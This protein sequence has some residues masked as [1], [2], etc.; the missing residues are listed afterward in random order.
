MTVH[1]P[2]LAI[3]PAL[4]L[5]SAAGAPHAKPQKLGPSFDCARAA[6]AIETMICS[7]EE[8]SAY[9]RALGIAFAHAEDRAETAR[10]QRAWLNEDRA[11]CG[12]ADCLAGAYADRLDDLAQFPASDWGTEY[13]SRSAQGTLQIAPIGGGWYMFAASATWEYAH[14]TT[15]NFGDAAG[16]IRPVA[17]RAEFH[18]DCDLTF[19]RLSGDRWRIRDVGADDNRCGGV[20][21]NMTGIY[22]RKKRS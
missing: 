6:G 5:C 15:T 16:V 17:G 20:N 7:S 21:V 13:V 4:L 8:L 1:K 22:V 12:D 9:D 11:R 19:E 18:R 10:K 14:H 3:L 2:G